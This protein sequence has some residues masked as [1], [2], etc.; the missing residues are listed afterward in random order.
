[1]PFHSE[2]PKSF[3]GP[4]HA[5][6]SAFSSWG[7]KISRDL[8][9]SQQ[10]GHHVGLKRLLAI[11]VLCLVCL[12]V[13]SPLTSADLA[14]PEATTQALINLQEQG[15]DRK[16]ADAVTAIKQA[17]VHTRIRHFSKLRQLL[18]A[19][20]ALAHKEEDF[21]KELAV[22][23]RLARLPAMKSKPEASNEGSESVGSEVPSLDELDRSY[24]KTLLAIERDLLQQQH[25]AR[26]HLREA[27]RLSEETNHTE[28]LLQAWESL[29]QCQVPWSENL[30]PWP[31]VPAKDYDLVHAIPIPELPAFLEVT[32]PA[33][34]YDLHVG[35]RGRDNEDTM[36]IY[37]GG[38]FGRIDGIRATPGG[39][40][41]AYAVHF[42]F[43]TGA[44]KG[45]VTP[46]LWPD[47]K[48]STM[49]PYLPTKL[50]LSLSSAG[51]IVSR[52]NPEGYQTVLRHEHLTNNPT[53]FL[54]RS[55]TLFI[56]SVRTFPA[57][58]W[59]DVSKRSY[60][61]LSSIPNF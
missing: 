15:W 35:I 24:E 54:F 25:H 46:S 44:N 60:P 30:L 26:Q 19:Q 5:R 42:P 2:N 57:S 22:L 23:C 9:G 47:D 11:P 53:A 32:V 8:R 13:A 48:Q 37:V 50:R 52:L 55:S 43:F 27:M 39:Q 28:Q 40:E 1:M 61:P 41:I 3:I 51:I 31:F 21:T 33:S 34:S 4:Q 29:A 38:H 18:M 16:M 10:S 56:T 59:A 6:E 58:T 36:E 49:H 20:R 14:L 17:E 12:C 45:S 7:R